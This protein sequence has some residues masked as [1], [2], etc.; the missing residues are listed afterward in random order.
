MSNRL[1]KKLLLIGWDAADWKIAGPLVDKGWMPGLEYLINRGVM[2]NLATLNPILS[3]MLWNSIATGKTADKHGILG[4]MEPDPQTGGI[5]PVSS[6]SRKVKAIWNILTQKGF[7]AHVLGWFAGHPAEPIRGVS[8]SDLYPHAVAPLGKEWPLPSGA[9]YPD[10]LRNTFAELRMHPGEVQPVALLPFVPNAAR[11]DQKKDLRLRAIAKVLTENLSIHNAATWILENRPWDFMAVYYNGIDHF[12][13]GFMHFHPPCMEGIPEEMFEI[14]KDVVTGAYRLQDLLLVRMLELAGPDT[15]VLVVSDHGFHPDHLRPRS[16]PEEPAG[17]AVQHRRYGV[18][19]LK[20]PGIK[21][22]E[23]IYGAN[24]LDITPTVL[25]LFG[26]PV[27]QDMDGRVLVQAFE[28]PPTVERIPSW[29][30]ESGECGMH[31]ADLRMDPAAAQAVLAQFVALGYIQPPSKNQ[32]TARAVATREANY[33]LARVYLDSFRPQAAL[34]LLEELVKNDPAEFRFLEHLAKCYYWLRRNQDAKRILEDL[35][36]NP[37]K[38]KRKRNGEAE[39]NSYSGTA[40]LESAAETGMSEPGQEEEQEAILKAEDVRTEIG[41]D[42]VAQPAM[43]RASSPDAPPEISANG[44]PAEP[45]RSAPWADWLM[46]VICFEEG[47]LPEAL[48][49]LLRA[50][51][52]DPRLPGLHLHIGNAYLRMRQP[53]DAERAFQKAVDIDGDSAEA[54]LG[55]AVV[56]I[57]K[58]RNEEAAEQALIAVGL[59]HFLPRGHYALGV[60]L[61]RLAIYDR[62]T[63]AFETVLTILPGSAAAHRWLVALYSRP[64]GNPALAAEHRRLGRELWKKKKAKVTQ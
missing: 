42:G 20:G 21:Q 60:S 33:N 22:D 16:I 14:Y 4:F 51:Q 12:C 31:A 19:C 30:T 48:D 18:I 11:I 37:P 29:E 54:H 52:A 6:T 17:P 3:P 56:H 46:G 63:L 32:E 26:L 28:E 43:P 41:G 27:G 24:L 45:Q 10:S 59:Q 13:H 62:A 34:P 61:A 40:A 2:G 47:N 9:V 53:D 57:R 39:G 7:D 58:R 23:R 38:P 36:R 55:L 50:E 15:T 64:D 44:V 1:A 25:T 35:I 49:R 8:V 5:R